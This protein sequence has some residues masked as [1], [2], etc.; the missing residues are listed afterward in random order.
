LVVFLGVF[1]RLCYVEGDVLG[2]GDGGWGGGGVCFV[3]WFGVVCVWGCFGFVCFCF[4]GCFLL[5]VGG[6]GV[7]GL[8]CGG[9]VCLVMFLW[10]GWFGG[11]VWCWFCFGCVAFVGVGLVGLGGVVGGG[12]WGVGGFL[13][14][15]CWFVWCLGGVGGGWLGLFFGGVFMLFGWGGLLCCVFFW[16]F[17]GWLFCLGGVWGEFGGL[18]RRVVFMGVGCLCGGG[19]VFL[20]LCW[21]FFGFVFCGL[22]EGVGGLL[23]VVV[24]VV[25]FCVGLG[26]GGGCL[27]VGTNA[28]PHRPHI[29]A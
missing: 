18:L 2:E 20:W 25:I 11:G 19:V 3:W 15:V 14:F 17:V 22:A 24:V 16:F 5:C 6:G 23:L 8:G 4:W 10:C 29:R 7:V 26:F 9:G 21:G 13:G 12:V 28:N 1:L 27:W